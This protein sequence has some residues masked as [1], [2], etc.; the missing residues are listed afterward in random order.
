MRF[1][2]ST[3]TIMATLRQRVR[4]T[5]LVSKSPLTKAPP[6]G[7]YGLKVDSV[8]ET[9]SLMQVRHSREVADGDG[10]PC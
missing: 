2:S 8:W 7:I 1:E 9:H 4:P 10:D 3:E 6:W 5:S